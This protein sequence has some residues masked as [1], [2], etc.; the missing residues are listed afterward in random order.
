MTGFIRLIENALWPFRVVWSYGSRFLRYGK[1]A[2]GAPKLSLAA[3]I[4]FAFFLALAIFITVVWILVAF[5]PQSYSHAEIFKIPFVD[6]PIYYLISILLAV[7]VY[8]SIRLATRERPS[9]YPEIDQCWQPIESWREKQGLGWQEFHRY[10][11]IGA[12]LDVSKAMHAEMKDRKLGPL[13][14]GVNDWM[15]WFGTNSSVYLH[16]KKACHINDRLSRLAGKSGAPSIDPSSTLQASVG[17]PDW[18]GSVG[19]DAMTEEVSG[20][21]DSVEGFEDSLEPGASLDPYA[22]DGDLAMDDIDPNE[23]AAANVTDDSDEEE[24]GEDGDMPSDRVKYVCQLMRNR[25]NGEMPFNGVVV[26][27]PYDKFM[28]RENYKTIAN[29]IKKDLLQIR[30]QMGVEFPVSFLFSSMEKDQGFPKLQ[31]LL[32]AKRS[33]SGRFGAG[34]RISEIPTVEKSNLAVQ[35]ERACQSFEDW[36]TNRWGKSSQLSRAAQNKELY[37]MVIRVRQKFRPKLIYMLEHTMLWGD[38]E[39]SGDDVDLTLAG[40]YFASTGEHT[41][42]RGFLNGVFLK[43]DEFAETASWGDSMVQRDRV[44]SVIATLISLTAIATLIG[45]GIWMFIG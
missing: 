25:T 42:E 7:A 14:A 10:L 44:Q 33:E 37:K 30:E 3:K 18:S 12:D 43:C 23:M 15:H 20:Y 19:V 36:V 1:Q 28:H 34:C 40:C 5:D 27:V 9:L 13:P 31:N 35:V 38:S 11:V 26:V 6:Y 8:W 41:A 32:G 39:T 22:D 29:S 21:G 2:Q 24:I 45:I 16:L 17:V 4:A